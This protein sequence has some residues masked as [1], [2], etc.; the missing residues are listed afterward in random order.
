MI[1]LLLII[2]SN[3]IFQ[4]CQAW[5]R[6][7]VYEHT[8]LCYSADDTWFRF[9]PHYKHDDFHVKFDDNG[10][11]VNC[12]EA[13]YLKL[14]RIADTLCPNPRLV[15]LLCKYLDQGLRAQPQPSLTTLLQSLRLD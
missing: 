14:V 3:A 11:C 1:N 12:I 4:K 2:I 6:N 9:M 10:D 7:L 13:F 15:H 8:F 5:V